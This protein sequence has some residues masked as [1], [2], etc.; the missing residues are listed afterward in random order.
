M[1]CLGIAPE[2]TDDGSAATATTA[3]DFKVDPLV[4][5]LFLKLS[6]GRVLMARIVEHALLPPSAVQAVLPT[7]LDIL[8]KT[9]RQQEDPTDDR[10]FRALTSVVQTL[11]SLSGE[12]MMQCAEVM[13]GNSQAALSSTCRM[14]CLHALL[15]RGTGMAGSPE[16]GDFAGQWKETESSFMAILSGM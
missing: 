1:K 6:K 13:K 8:Y 3:G 14:E 9:P 7:T 12:A 16:A 5:Q 4:L 11:P 2:S 10:C 15:Q